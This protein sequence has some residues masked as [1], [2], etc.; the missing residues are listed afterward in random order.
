MN[1]HNNMTFGKLMN[2]F[3]KKNKTLFVIY[4]LLIL[5]IPLR[6]ILMPHMIGKLYTNIKTNKP[7][8]IILII[9]ISVVIVIQV[10]TIVSD[11]IE[12][13]LHPRIYQHVREAI[14]THLFSTRETNYSDIEIGYIIS[15]IVKLPSIIHN[16]VDQWRS[17]Y[18]PAIITLLAA[19]IY[20]LIVDKTLGIAL[21][22]IILIIAVT[23]YKSFNECQD[24][25]IKK[26]E[27]FS[28]MF[29]NVDDVLQ[30]MMTV[31][32]FNKINDEFD[33]LNVLQ[34]QYAEY[35]EATL[36][37][38]IT[39]KLIILP[40]MLL[41]IFFVCIYYYKKVQK[42]ELETGKFISL[43]IILFVVMKTVLSL[44]DS[45]KEL[46]MRWGVIKNSL[47]VFE[48]CSHSREPYDKDADILTGIHI[49]DLTYYYGKRKVFDN[50]NLNIRF[51]EVTLII[52]EIGSGKSTLVSLILKYQTPHNGEI[53]LNGNP[54]KNIDHHKLRQQIV[55]I[56]QTPILLNRSIYEN[57][58][59]GLGSEITIEHVLDVMRE[60][61]LQTFLDSLPDGLNTPVGV[62]G[63][64]LSGGQR[65][66]VWII[67]AVLLN[68]D[69]IIMDEPTASVDDSTKKTIHYLL[70]KVMAGRTV[71]MITHDPYL[72]KFA[73]R[74]ITLDN[75]VILDDNV[76]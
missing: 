60:L 47:R 41:Y 38:S 15:K 56:P 44:L 21:T 67:K 20:F 55:Y 24:I 68:P 53:F 35:T 70:E 34:D 64:K 61:D 37:C 30:N 69:I 10:F 36:K 74:I 14:M 16:Y 7:V 49:Q 28:V 57:I 33:N 75:G 23:L 27:V 45:L 63:S 76:I 13:K 73:N 43:M 59:Y 46:I 66:I 72:H 29:G 40:I 50:F 22:V 32:S 12:F 39:P 58:T 48:Q 9:I 26:D 19:I 11:F 65:Q 54:Y 31:M 71:I 62:H 18:F 42:S 1:C 25:S 3:I 8:I 4:I 52:G 2:D 5:T 51:N 17:K 6:D